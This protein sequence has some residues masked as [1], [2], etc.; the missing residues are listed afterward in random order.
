MNSRSRQIYLLAAVSLLA[1][2]CGAV[3]EQHTET[4]TRSWPASSIQR[5]NV[6]EIDGSVDVT[7]GPVN[8][9][10]L[11]AHVRAR[12]VRPNRAKENDGYFETSL[13]GD[14]LSIGNRHHVRMR[15]PFFYSND[16]SV[17]YE[18]RIPPTVAL[19]LKTVNGRIA[20]RGV[21]SEMEATT[22]NGTLDLETSGTRE[23]VAN[24][25]NGRVKARFLREFQ[26]ARLKT[27]NGS[28]EAVL[29]PTA[30]FA[31]DLSQVNGDFEASFPLSIHSHPGRR[32]VSGEVNGGR[33]D[34]QITTVN[35]DIHI[36][37]GPAALTAPLPPSAPSAIPAPPAIPAAPAAPAPPP[38]PPRRS[39]R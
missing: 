32:R 35:G 6:N 19:D 2:G 16:V 29:P 26:G 39:T 27:V 10:S 38:M 18:L 17:D 3:G 14:T 4:I 1:M 7:A 21:D 34:L 31:C 9:I 20:T 24:A 28:V 11:V 37:N 5:I 30:S 22:I 12:G 25:V 36:D 33:F 8:E 23:L 15:I 13:G